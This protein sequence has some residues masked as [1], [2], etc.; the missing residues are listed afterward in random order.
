MN[1]AFGTSCLRELTEI[2]FDKA[3]ELRDKWAAEVTKQNGSG[4]IDALS[5]LTRT[6]LDVI[7]LAGFNYKFNA[8][9]DPETDKL[10]KAF[11]TVFK[12]DSSIPVISIIRGLFP[13]LRFLPAERDAESKRAMQTMARIGRQILND[14][15]AALM[16]HTA[17]DTPLKKDLWSGRD[18]LSLLVR[19]NMATDLP[20]AQ[21]MSDEDVLAQVPT[22]LVAGHETTSSAT[23]WAL[24]ALTQNPR[25]QEKLREELLNITTDTPTMDVLNALPYLDAVVRE[26]MRVHAPVSSTVR[27]AM[28]DDVVPLG[29]PIKGKD[30]RS[31][32]YIRVQRGQTVFIPLQAVNSLVE[33]WGEDAQEFKPERWD[34]IPDAANSIPGAWGNIL[35]FLGGPRAC[36]GYKFALIEMK[37]I[38]F[39]LVRAFEFQ[40]AVPPGEIKKIS[41]IVQRPVLASDP[42]SS[43]QMP[44]IVKHHQL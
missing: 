13:A 23:T 24:Y 36:I 2:F 7:G 4:R 6:T 19:A 8:L 39:T 30:G 44:L 22:F 25:A 15:K 29:H 42:D 34:S 31:R 40:L 1:P 26:T 9:S 28:R 17:A 3:I 18:L 10:H 33:I 20:D 27:V 16:A 41:S 38:L 35:S 5:W 43:N 11:A 12:A 37:A 32:E 21:R 14:S